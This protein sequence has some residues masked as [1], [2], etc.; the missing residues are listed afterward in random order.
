MKCPQPLILVKKTLRDTPVGE[1]FKL[2]TQSNNA[3]SNIKSF[4]ADNNVK[5]TVDDENGKYIFSITIPESLSGKAN[6]EEYCDD[7]AGS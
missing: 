1:S 7:G 4:L 3:L 2:I 5:F 6:P